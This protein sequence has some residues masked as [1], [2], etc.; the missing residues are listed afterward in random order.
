MVET[1]K[2]RR[3]GEG[4]SNYVEDEDGNQTYCEDTEDNPLVTRVRK[5]YRFLRDHRTSCP[6]E[7]KVFAVLKHNLFKLNEQEVWN[8]IMGMDLADE[9]SS[10]LSYLQGVFSAEDPADEVYCE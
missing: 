3:L 2:M 7:A 10:L 4:M 1:M 8:L 9:H 6:G 5:L